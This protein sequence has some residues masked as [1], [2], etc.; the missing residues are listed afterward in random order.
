MS[1]FDTTSFSSFAKTALSQAHNLQKSIDRVLDIEDDK[2]DAVSKLSSDLSKPFSQPVSSESTN[3]SAAARKSSPSSTKTVSS[4]KLPSDDNN[5]AEGNTFWSSFLGDSFSSESSNRVSNVSSRRSSE[6]KCSRRASGTVTE[7]KR[8]GSSGVKQTTENVDATTDSKATLPVPAST[9]QKCDDVDIE[10]NSKLQSN[11]AASSASLCQ[12]RDT[13]DGTPR[14]KPIFDASKISDV[15]EDNSQKLCYDTQGLSAAAQRNNHE[16][17]SSEEVK[18]RHESEGALLNFPSNDN[19]V[20]ANSEYINS[21]NFR[22]KNGV[23]TVT[24]ED[25]PI[26]KSR[27][28]HQTPPQVH[29][30]MTSTEEQTLDQK[31]LRKNNLGKE[32]VLVLLIFHKINRVQ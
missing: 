28:Q 30:A 20:A 23:G 27:E 32:K 14:I 8:R 29:T 6:R 12:E 1:W 24:F 3:E 26:I 15:D 25:Q 18:G 4:R 31:M 21:K 17:E 10:K 16:L 11:F 13:E 7:G 2:K 22:D 9:E 19:V 5:S